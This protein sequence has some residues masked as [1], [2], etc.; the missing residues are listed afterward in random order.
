MLLINYHEA[1]DRYYAEYEKQDICDGAEDRDWLK[2]CFDEAPAVDPV[3]TAGGCYC[4]E[5]IYQTYDEE[6]DQR[7]CNRDLG[8]RAVRADGLGF[9]DQGMETQK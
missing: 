6:F 1:I 5:C 7:W 9:C 2:R 4:K 8:C 3:H